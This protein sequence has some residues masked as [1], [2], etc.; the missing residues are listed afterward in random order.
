MLGPTAL[1][2]HFDDLK[3]QK[4]SAELGMWLFLSTEI[5]L[6]GG[7]FAAYAVYRAM[8]PEAWAEGSHHNNLVLG[9]I[10]TAVLLVSSLTMAL[11]V[12]AAEEERWR[13]VSWFLMGTIVL[14]AAFLGIKFYEYYEH[15]HHHVVPGL[16][17]ELDSPHAAQ[18]EMFM[19]FY[20]A[21]T[22]LH[23][24]HMTIGIGV[25]G[26][27]AVLAWREKL[28]YYVPIEIT[29]LYWHLVDIVWV[30]L[31]PMLYLIG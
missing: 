27:M 16:H 23:A 4:E 11:A 14:G 30:F 26:V 8:Y 24:L 22:L 3:Q 17:F 10:N 7:V 2:H 20:F 19:F 21:M 28:A 31:F 13:V 9:T 6:F 18:V 5:L 15:W 1:E 25:V 29:G 12:H